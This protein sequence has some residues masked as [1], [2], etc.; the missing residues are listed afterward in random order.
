[1]EFRCP[2]CAKCF[3]SKSNLARHCIGLH[4]WSLTYSAPLA[5]CPVAPPKSTEASEAVIN[6]SDVEPSDKEKSTESIDLPTEE[7]DAAVRDLLASQELMDDE[8]EKD[9]VSTESGAPLLTPGTSSQSTAGG[10]AKVKVRR[11]WEEALNPGATERKRTR[12]TQPHIPPPKTSEKTGET[13]KSEKSSGGTKP[14]LPGYKSTTAKWPNRAACPS[15]RDII[16]YRRS[17]PSTVTPAKIGELAQFRFEWGET[18]A[19]TSRRYVQGVVSGYDAGR[20][21][22]FQKLGEYL[23]ESPGRNP[24]PQ[25]R[26]NWIRHWMENDPLP[27]I[28]EQDFSD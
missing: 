3:V 8:R 25:E 24:E 21:A 5:E 16:G 26:I 2:K 1:M 23:R 10:N 12:V 22:V 28:P 14:L 13:S 18:K 7:I 27:T 9:G 19:V 15:I 4:S 11:S 17:L 20:R 6:L